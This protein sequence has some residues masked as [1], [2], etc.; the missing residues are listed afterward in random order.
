VIGELTVMLIAIANIYPPRYLLLNIAFTTQLLP[1]SFVTT[2][3]ILFFE[4]WIWYDI[5]L[6]SVDGVG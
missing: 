6:Q 4:H 1:F 2:S 5:H 3:V